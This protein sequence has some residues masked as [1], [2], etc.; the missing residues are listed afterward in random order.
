MRRATDRPRVQ[1]DQCVGER[2]DRDLWRHQQRHLIEDPI[3]IRDARLGPQLPP[4]SSSSISSTS[5]PTGKG[6]L[7]SVLGISVPTRRHRCARRI[8]PARSEP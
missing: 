5:E 2:L 7:S 8:R 1:L 4:R 6:A 3:D